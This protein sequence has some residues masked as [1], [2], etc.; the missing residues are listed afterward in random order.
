MKTKLFFSSDQIESASLISFCAEN[1]LELY[2]QS[3]ID[4]ESIPFEWFGDEA[5][6]FF[7]SPRSVSFF[8]KGI[9]RNL[10]EYV[11]ACVGKGTAS[12]L[13]RIGFKA[14][15]VGQQGGNPEQVA[16]E[17][18]KFAGG[19]KVLF[20]MAAES[21]QTISGLLPENQKNLLP[22]YRTIQK[23]VHIPECMI[24]VFTSPSNVN[25][26][27]ELNTVAETSFVIAWGSSTR[28]CL[29]TNGI[30]VYKS[31]N[32][33]GIPELLEVLNEIITQRN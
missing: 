10:D 27:L 28:S 14:E 6:I 1:N 22:V 8:T 17:F 5:I 16:Q 2:A 31:L 20:P 24:Y 29:E 26:F 33:A 32:K 19:R 4:W 23:S 12:A 30:R 21:L 15:F 11:L 25:A 7:S 13:Q 3:L 9:E 18:K